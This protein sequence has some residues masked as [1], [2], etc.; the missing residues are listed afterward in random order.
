MVSPRPLALATLLLLAAPLGAWEPPAGAEAR[1]PTPVLTAAVLV[2]AE[3][4][5]WAAVAPPLRATALRAY[6]SNKTDA[7]GAWLGL[8]RWA[9]LFAEREREFVPRWVAAINAAKVGHPNMARA[10]SPPD[11]RLGAYAPRP[12]QEWLLGD[13]AFTE[14]FFALLSPCD[15]L[16]TVLDTLGKLHAADPKKFAAYAQLALA[17]A[18]VHDVP[19]P[20]TWPHAQVSRAALLRRLPAPAELFAFLTEADAAGKTLHKLARLDAATLKFLADPAAPLDELDWARKTITPP[21]ARLDE[22]YALVRY[23]TDREQD[24]VTRWPGE[25]YGLPHI[26]AEGGI[27]VD[28]AYFA[29]QVG[30]A[31]GVP[32]L[33][34]RGA[35]DDGRHAWFGY[36]DGRQ[37]WQLDA[38]RYEEQNF[39]TGVAHDPQTWGDLSDHELAFLSEGFRGSVNYQTSRLHADFAAVRL[40]RKEA[41]AAL[42][43][44]RKAVAAERRNLTA[45]ETLLAAHAATGADAKAREAVLREAAQ[46]FDRYPDL[47]T[48]FRQRVA[49]SLRA[50][51]E[52]SAAELEESQIARRNQ[53]NRADL[54]IA[55]AALILRRLLDTRPAPPL[56]EQTQTYAR[57]VRQYGRDA[58]TAFYDQ[59]TQPFVARMVRDGHK[60]E[61]R[62]ALKQARDV[63][64]PA[65]GSQLAKEMDKLEATLR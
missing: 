14:R 63:L 11:N 6:E 47:N 13:R 33:I 38:G 17:L 10:Y 40:E 34:F 46:A 20:P 16:P 62:A 51:G 8:A 22:T 32:T 35:G 21:L 49:D 2:A 64:V 36:L 39:V 27:C 15:H 1:P 44:A 56:L 18:V 7:A 29:A 58:G 23:R 45:W 37:K 3:R 52:T 59:I 65:T 54:T 57:L 26:L 48:R 43:A 24:N 12:L 41:P 31:R 53:R 19:P 28:Q 9:A 60:P 61:A 25:T 55:Q 4:E 5:G 42:A 50:R 30:K